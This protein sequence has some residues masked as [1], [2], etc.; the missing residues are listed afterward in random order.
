M[1]IEEVRK[2]FPIT[3]EFCYLDAASLAPSNIYTKKAIEDFYDDALRYGISKFESW[4]DKIEECR[5]EAASLIKAKKSE[6]ALVKNASEGI[7][8]TALLISWKKGDRIILFKDDFPANIYP[9]LNLRK[10][11]VDVIFLE[12]QS[13]Y[14][15]EKA[16][17]KYEPKLLSISSV[18]YESGYRSDIEGIGK[19]CKKFNVLF[20]VDATQSLGALELDVK[21]SYIDFLSSS[22]YKWLLSPLGTGIF[23]I[24]KEL[25]EEFEMPFLGWLSI[26]N[27][28][29]LEKKYNNYKLL[30]SAKRF[31]FGSFNFSCFIGMLSSLKIIKKAGIKNI[32]KHVL[33]LR[34]TL[35]EELKTLE[36][37]KKIRIIDMPEEH[38]SAIFSFYEIKKKKRITKHMLIKSK[39]IATVRENIRLSPHIY[40]NEEDCIK[41]SKVIKNLI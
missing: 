13:L 6:I 20:H 5:K 10:K 4:K 22:G 28:W 2:L 16:I 34:G 32:E 41:A 21:K 31:E 26:K 39:V 17:K 9:F 3:E 23:F 35:K 7:N 27:G 1:R 11:G 36:E 37:K 18:F 40:N 19:I 30:E 14:E 29:K 24:R 38:A 25:L 33:K 12:S 15:I 8:L